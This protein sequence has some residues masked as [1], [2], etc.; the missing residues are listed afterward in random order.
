MSELIHL[1]Q[2]ESTNAELR[3]RAQEGS[4]ADLDALRADFQSDGR[5]QPGNSWESA[6]GQNLLISV[7]VKGRGIEACNHFILSMAVSL[8]ATDTVQAMLPQYLHQRLKIKWPNDIY[9]GDRKLGG[10]LI[11]NDLEGRVISQTIV[12]LGLNINQTQ[13]VSDAP[14]PVSL[15]SITGHDGSVS[16]AAETFRG[17]LRRRLEQL[18]H[19]EELRDQY[20]MMLL[21]ADGERHLFRDDKGHMFTARLADVELDGHL[22]LEGNN[23]QLLRYLFKEVSFIMPGQSQAFFAPLRNER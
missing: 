21:R 1:E 15:K 13:F 14:N 7:L 16:E 4:L 19:P 17:S 23:G 20:R 11:E 6:T 18:T 10:L 22:V 5:G 8:A 3:R 12:G 9:I 2:T